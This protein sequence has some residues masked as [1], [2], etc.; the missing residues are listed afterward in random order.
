M[1]NKKVKILSVLVFIIMFSLMLCNIALAWTPDTDKITNVTPTGN[2]E[3]TIYAIFGQ[4]VNILTIIGFGLGLIVL[5]LMGM[6]YMLSSV[7]KK[8]DI[9]K[10]CHA[11]VLGAFLLFGASAILQL[12]YSFIS[13]LN[14]AV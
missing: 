11:Y 3:N 5:I 6:Q 7:E 4:I 14:N 2:S 1:K 12:I 10:Q 13:G 9:K 8:A